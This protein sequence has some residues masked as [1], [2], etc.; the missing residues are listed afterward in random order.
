MWYIIP[1]EDHHQ[2][3]R[4]KRF[5]IA[6]ASYLMWMS[7]IWYCY[8]QGIFRMNLRDTLLIF[9]FVMLMNLGLYVVFR[10]GLNK[11][12]PDP[13]LTLL[14][15]SLAT[16]WIMIVAYHLNEA[17]GIMLLLYLV[18]FIFGAFRLNLRQFIILS[19]FATLSYGLVILLLIDNHPEV[20]N[21]HVELLYLVILSAVLC[22]FSFVG[23]YINTLRKKLS[24]A[25]SELH[26]AME[27]IRQKAIHDDLTGVYNRGY[28]FQILGREKSLADRGGPVFS[29]CIFDLDDFKKVNDT[30]GHHAGDAVLKTLSR[31]IK[32]NMRQQDYIARYGGEEFVL[33]LAYPDMRDAQKCVERIRILLS[34]AMFPDLPGDYSVTASM[35]LTRYRVGETIDSL[36]VRADNALYRAKRSGKNNLVCEPALSLNPAA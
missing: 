9:S 33:I 18:V 7:L 26:D 1:K 27:T 14:Q 10:T 36:L 4:M 32:E 16:V 8:I 23:S 11:L 17:R 3:L 6:W 35:G 20:I 21:L 30:F 24:K 13:S 22:W 29:L 12:R 28:L 31:I 5:L 34:Q 25:N 15:M 2:S 19:L